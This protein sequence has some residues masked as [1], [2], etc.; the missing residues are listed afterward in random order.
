MDSSIDAHKWITVAEEAVCW[1]DG[2][3][4]ALG[5]CQTAEG[6]EIHGLANLDP[7]GVA[8]YLRVLATKLQAV[9]TNLTHL[10]DHADLTDLAASLRPDGR[11]TQASVADVVTTHESANPLAG[12]TT[13]EL[14]DMLVDPTIA[15]PNLLD[16][17]LRGEGGA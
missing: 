9:A 12:K 7:A 6:I 4:D 14:L 16:R 17:E 1:V 5:A 10:A 2:A 11:T 3:L 8:E 13:E 15:P